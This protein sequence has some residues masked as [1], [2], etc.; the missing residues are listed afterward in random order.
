MLIERN[1]YK[2]ETQRIRSQYED[3]L[4]RLRRELDASSM[5]LS[6]ISKSKGN[7]VQ[8]VVQKFTAEKLALET[9]HRVRF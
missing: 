5:S 1:R 2:D 8:L 4:N 9:E 7:E 6:N 3:E